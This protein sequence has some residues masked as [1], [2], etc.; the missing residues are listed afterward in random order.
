MIIPVCNGEKYIESC[1]NSLFNND[2][3]CLFNVIVVN[4]G[5]NDRTPLIL[6]SYSI[7][8]RQAELTILD[9]DHKG[10]PY[11]LDLAIGH[12]NTEF[13][14]RLDIDDCCI[15]GRLQR[16]V[17]YLIDNPHI[18]VLGGQAQRISDDSSDDSGN[19][20]ITM[21][22]HPVLVQFSSF[23]HC[24]VLHPSVMFRKSVVLK[25]GGY[26]SIGSC[27]DKDYVDV[28]EDYYLWSRLSDIYPCSIAN[29]PS[30]IIQLR[31]HKASKSKREFQAASL[32][33]RRL[34]LKMWSELI[35]SKCELTEKLLSIIL[36][37]ETEIALVEDKERIAAAVLLLQHMKE[38][39]IIRY[40]PA[41]KSCSSSSP[42][43]SPSLEI[44]D[45]I[46]LEEMERIVLSCLDE[47]HQ[48]YV[49]QLLSCAV[50][51]F[52]DFPIPENYKEDFQ[53]IQSN[54][55]KASILSN[56]AQFL[57]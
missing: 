28:I 6:S 39:F 27:E 37:P 40:I 35:E 30:V 21:Q 48:R 52:P 51:K 1:L 42:N 34:Q 9:S 47:F 26:Q 32:A 45:S 5:S 10:L 55:L 17:S 33:T 3:G 49:F 44:K 38:A 36:K 56:L 23:F 7:E 22:T 46:V 4:D 13:I 31:M 25:C 18:A 53:L 50:N 11:A 54:Q 24:P 8:E 2:Q 41:Y 12:S 57:H 29:S 16:Q 19:S 43:L 14:A 20:C 15:E